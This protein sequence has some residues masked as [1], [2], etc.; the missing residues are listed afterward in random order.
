MSGEQDLDRNEPAT[1]FK[2]EK[3]RRKGS[4][5]KS[6]EATF[7]VMLVVFTAVVYGLLEQTLKDMARLIGHAFSVGISS[8]LSLTA[9]PQLTSV[10]GMEAVVATAP[11]LLVV[12]LAALAFG[13]AQARGV[14][15]TEPLKPNIDRINPAA[16]F[17]RLFS[18]RTLYDV[19]R[20]GLKLLILG[21][22]ATVWGATH[23]RD[24]VALT[25]MAPAGLLRHSLRL[26]GSLLVLLAT[27][28]A[29]LACVDWLF[30]RWEYMRQMRMSKREMKDE[31]K[32]REGDPRIKARLRELRAEWARRAKSV[33]RVGDADVLLTN[34]THFAVAVQYKHGAMPAP[35]LLAKGAGELAQRMRREASRRGV[36]V[37]QNPPLARA[38]FVEVP[39]D[40]FIPEEHFQ[41]VARILRWVYAARRPGTAAA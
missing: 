6:Q 1:G 4:I 35:L 26:F 20:T 39:Q 21:A 19:A 14:L 40:Q 9:L 17:K 29:L 28:Y 2:L 25:A 23:L 33:Q 16:N 36:P 13:A 15:S 24:F 18:L 37:V 31:H 32:D 38:L 12:W 8:D 22:T 3:A 7:A 27:V 5:A 11:M 41:Q 34:P 30:S 10:L